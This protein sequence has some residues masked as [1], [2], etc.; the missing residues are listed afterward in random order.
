MTFTKLNNRTWISKD[1]QTFIELYESPNLSIKT[2][3]LTHKNGLPV[4]F[5]KLND[6]KRF[7]KTL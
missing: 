3:T 5:Y 6:A 2:Y 1:G 4:D 7:A